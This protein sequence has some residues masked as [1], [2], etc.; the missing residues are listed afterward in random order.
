MRLSRSFISAFHTFFVALMWLNGA[1]PGGI[2]CAP[3]IASH[4]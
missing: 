3:D 1:N 4:R 2:S